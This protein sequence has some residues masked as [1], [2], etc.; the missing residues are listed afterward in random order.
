MFSGSNR[1]S[2]CIY[3]V[4]LCNTEF[5]ERTIT[6]SDIDLSQSISALAVLRDSF[7]Y[8]VTTC[9]L[10]PIQDRTHYELFRSLK[11]IDHNFIMSLCLF[12]CYCLFAIEKKWNSFSKEITICILKHSGINCFLNNSMTLIFH[13]FALSI[14]GV[15]RQ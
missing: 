3:A 8:V 10:D 11:K 15:H 2:V 13:T 14:Y 7:S 1:R 4:A 5:G 6:C 9:S 12:R